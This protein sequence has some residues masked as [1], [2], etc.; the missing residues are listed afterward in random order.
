MLR[1]LSV[2][3][4][5]LT[6]ASAFGLYQIK[7]DTRQL[8]AKLQAGERAIEKMEGDIAVLKAEKAYLARP[9]RIEALARKQGLGP[10]GGHQYVLPG[11]LQAQVK[12]G[13]RAIEK[14]GGDAALKAEKADQARP[15]S[16][17]ALIRQQGLA[18]GAPK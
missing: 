16:I 4:M 8:E 10:V 12:A 3:A 13:E 14:M 18:P 1:L 9:E 6:I 11:E 17:E 5:A 7:Y 2:A 15:D